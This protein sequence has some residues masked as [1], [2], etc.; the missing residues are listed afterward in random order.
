MAASKRGDASGAGCP[1]C[2]RPVV[3]GQ[4]PAELNPRT[5]KPAAEPF[6]FCSG[7]CQLIDLG[8]WL[9]EEYRIPDRD[10]VVWPLPDGGL[11]DDGGD[12]RG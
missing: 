6:P 7:R 8:R 2:G 5:G 11:G 9:G 3:R 4:G 12:E 1:I 10:T